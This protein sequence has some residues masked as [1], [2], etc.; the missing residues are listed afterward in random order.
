MRVDS[1]LTAPIKGYF[2]E[3]YT[4]PNILSVRTYL[5]CVSSVYNAC[6]TTIDNIGVC[7]DRHTALDLQCYA[8][9][10]HL[11]VQDLDLR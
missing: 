8:L 11:A 5:L 3:R 1:M 4:A 9:L 7:Y 2:R 6:Y 10:A